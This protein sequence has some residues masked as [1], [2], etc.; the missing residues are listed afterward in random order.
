LAP[1]LGGLAPPL[2]TFRVKLET[3]FLFHKYVKY[4]N[5]HSEFESLLW[6]LYTG[7]K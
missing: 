2:L 3:M 4:G 5:F 1:Q 6:R 7:I